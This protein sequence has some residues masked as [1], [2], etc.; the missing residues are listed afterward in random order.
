MIQ[1]NCHKDY[2][3]K[4]LEKGKSEN[5]LSGAYN[6][7]IIRFCQ[8]IIDGWGK[9]RDLPN[10]LTCMGVYALLGVFG[11]SLIELIDECNN[12]FKITPE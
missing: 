11:K 9:D 3:K 10:I 4:K 2:L 6:E 1:V 12:K 8:N 7:F 5:P